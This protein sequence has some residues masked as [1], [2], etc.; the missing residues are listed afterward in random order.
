MDM[1]TLKVV[2]FVDSGV[3]ARGH[4]DDG[5]REHAAGPV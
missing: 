4:D 5:Q 2:D 3:P 1:N